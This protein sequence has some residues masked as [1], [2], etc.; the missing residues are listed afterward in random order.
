MS[1]KPVPHKNL[2]AA[3]EAL[4]YFRADAPTKSEPRQRVDT[5][6]EQMYAYYA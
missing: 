6:L 5:A 3:D 4:A 2:A 1:K